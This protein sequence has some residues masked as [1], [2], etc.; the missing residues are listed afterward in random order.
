MK[1]GHLLFVYGTLR[2][3]EPKGL[4]DDR[5][6]M[7]LGED[8]INGLMYSLGWYPGVKTEPG[9]FDPGK[10]T[11]IGDVFLIRD[12]AIVP[13]LDAY[14]GYPNLYDRLETETANGRHVWVYTYKDD[15]S[16]FEPLRIGDWTLS[17]KALTEQPVLGVE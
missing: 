5:R 10:P 17:K 8:Q 4:E 14:E 13:H 16:H 6:V 12:E 7:F 3:G 9:H 11:I 2:R 1:Q 15:L